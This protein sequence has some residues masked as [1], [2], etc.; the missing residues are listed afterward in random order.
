MIDR[1]ENIMTLPRRR[2]LRLMA[3]AAALAAMPRH[4][5]AETYPARP[6]TMVAPF[7]AGG[8]ADTIG[9]IVA[10]R[11][12]DSLGQSVVV[13]NVT[14]AAGSIGPGRVLRA[15]NDGYTISLGTSGTHV[16]NGAT[17][18]L[19]YDVVK[20]FDPIALLSTQPMMIVA[21]KDMP[22]K[23][24]RELI[25]WLKANPDQA[26]QGSTGLGSS[27]H[28]AGVLFQQLTGTRFSFVPYRGTNLAM[29]DLV[30]GRIDLIFDLSSLSIPLV[31][32]GTIKAY[33][34]MANSRL[35]AVPEIPTT[36]EAGLPGFHASVWMG[37]WARAGTSKDITAKLNAAVVNAL[38]N[39]VVR[40]RLADLGHEVFPKDQQTPEALAAF[41]KS[42]IDKWWPIIKA[43]GIKVN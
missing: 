4:A 26:K 16:V 22:A 18:T 25:A 5:A 19:P 15:A 33:A 42:E 34:I 17:M 27:I 40:T 7:P 32:A 41:Q 24:L 38:S 1:S 39:Q 10:E 6:I 11:M 2:A 3:G 31:R 29:Q 21:R 43:A 30:A 35:P 20:D 28:L 9:R 8:A 13:E 23:D 36:D 37:L 14:G 12:Q